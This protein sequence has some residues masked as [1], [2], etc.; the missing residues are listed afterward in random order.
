MYIKIVFKEP[1]KELNIEDAGVTVREGCFW[2]YP[3]IKGDPENPNTDIY[4]F[5]IIEKVEIREGDDEAVNRK[6]VV[7]LDRDKN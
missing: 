6:K 7:K 4:P 3:D 2:V 1:G 5:H